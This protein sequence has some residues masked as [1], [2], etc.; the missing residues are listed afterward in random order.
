M[1][2]NGSAGATKCISRTE[3]N[4]VL[5][6]VADRRMYGRRLDRRVHLGPLGSRS[7]LKETTAPT[8]INAS[9]RAPSVIATAVGSLTVRSA[10]TGTAASGAGIGSAVT[11]VRGGLE[12]GSRLSQR[13]QFRPSHQ[14]K[15]C[16]T[17]AGSAYQPGSAPSP[18]Q[19]RREH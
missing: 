18:Q 2:A 13:V 19:D 9:T 17:P 15:F 3:A 4:R 5:G 1:H 6:V 11:S 14:R 8:A 7:A 16:A 12:V 10:T